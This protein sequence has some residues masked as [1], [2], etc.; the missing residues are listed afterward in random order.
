VRHFSEYLQ[1]ENNHAIKMAEQVT[2]LVL[3]EVTVNKYI[4]TLFTMH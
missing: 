2:V 3:A 1:T 4:F